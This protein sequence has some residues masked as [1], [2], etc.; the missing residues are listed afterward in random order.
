MTEREED[1][2]AE[3]VDK[4]SRTSGFT[5]YTHSVYYEESVLTSEA[6]YLSLESDYADL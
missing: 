1:K 4:S 5:A 6:Q 3:A 2:R